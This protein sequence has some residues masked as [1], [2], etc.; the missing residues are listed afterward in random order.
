MSESC[1]PCQGLTLFGT[2]HSR[3]Q[4]PRVY[5]FEDVAIAIDVDTAADVA[6]EGLSAGEIPTFPWSMD[7]SE[8]LGLC[9]S[10]AAADGVGGVRTTQDDG[11]NS[12]DEAMF[13]SRESPEPIPLAVPSLLIKPYDSK[14]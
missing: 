11:V 7:E 4:G 6:S 9:F 3:V 14:L 13:V 5:K 1:Q 10:L 2:T 8:D 12:E